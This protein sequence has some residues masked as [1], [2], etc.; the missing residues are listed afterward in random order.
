MTERVF[1]LG[2]LLAPCSLLGFYQYWFMLHPKKDRRLQLLFW[3]FGGVSLAA[4]AF[5]DAAW[6]LAGQGTDASGYITITI[7]VLLP[8]ILLACF[9]DNWRRKLFVVIL[10]ICLQSGVLAP[11]YVWFINIA[12]ENG[13]NPGVL[14]YLI[15]YIG[16]VI[17]TA[18]SVILARGLVRLAETL[19]DWAYTSMAVLSPWANIAMNLEQWALVRAADKATDIYGEAFGRLIVEMAVLLTVFW[20]VYRGITRRMVAATASREEMHRSELEAEEHDLETLR[21][22]RQQHRRCLEEVDALLKEGSTDAA[23][24]RVREMTR[25]SIRAVRRYAD[26]PVADVALADA[27]YRCD[28]AGVELEIRGSLARECTLPPVDLASLFYNLFSNAVTAA[29]Q[30]P[31]PARV[32]IEFAQAAGC[33]CVTVRNPVPAH[34]AG[35]RGKDHGFGRKILQDITRRYQGSYTLTVADGIAEATALVTLPETRSLQKGKTHA[36]V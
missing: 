1:W 18:A 3:I 28:K 21:R 14:G 24:E 7:N 30:A 17:A 33:L 20:I 16:S 32:E 19:P 34:P 15:M 12:Q 22:L 10:G 9:A 23:L 4:K 5:A 26:N 27:A 2:L 11:F 8:F 6:K 35:P 29:A 13:G 36:F 25:S 31:R